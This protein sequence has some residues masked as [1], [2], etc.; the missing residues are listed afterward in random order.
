MPAAAVPA[1][2]GAVGGI[3]SALIGSKGKKTEYTSGRS[4]QA[5]ALESQVSNYISQGLNKPIAYAN[6]NPMSIQAM[7]MISKMFMGQGYTQPGY[8]QSAVGG[9]PS[10]QIYG[11]PQTQ[12]QQTSYGMS[13]QAMPQS[14]LRQFYGPRGMASQR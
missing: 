13:S 6:V 14:G 4:P 11:M 12:S 10:S 8:G 9:G 2:I 5:T 7:D 1:I 3:G